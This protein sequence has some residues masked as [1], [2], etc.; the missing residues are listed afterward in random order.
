MKLLFYPSEK[1]TKGKV[2]DFSFV[3][4]IFFKREHKRQ[5][6]LWRNSQAKKKKATEPL[7]SPFGMSDEQ[8]KVS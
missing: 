8:Q 1:E 7:S 3:F 4:V 6:L 5:R 2:V